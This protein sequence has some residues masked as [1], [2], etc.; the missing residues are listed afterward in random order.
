MSKKET[1]QK[2]FDDYF[3]FLVCKSFKEKGQTVVVHRYGNVDVRAFIEHQILLAKVKAQIRI[4]RWADK[5]ANGGLILDCRVI[6][7]KSIALQKQLKKLESNTNLN[8]SS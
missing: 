6:L 8:E 4:L 7:K 3:H 1:W 5:Q 2:E